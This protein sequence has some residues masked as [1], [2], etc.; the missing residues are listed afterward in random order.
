MNKILAIIL[1]IGIAFAITTIGSISIL[2]HK[3]ELQIARAATNSSSSSNI[4][5]GN[6]TKIQ[7]GVGQ[8]NISESLFSP[9]K[10]QIKLG[11]SVTWYN[12][13]P[14]AEPHTVSFVLDNKTMTNIITPFAIRNITELVPLPP[15][16]NSQPTTVPGKNIVLLLN[17][18]V[19]NPTII[20][21]QGKVKTVP[22]NSNYTMTSSEK[23]VN[24][25]FIL[26]K[27]KE[28]AYPGSG[29]SFT[30]RF[31]KAGTYDYICV[32]HPWMKG[33]VTVK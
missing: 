5:I 8:G 24:S 15:G 25:G 6:V 23:F 10:V 27:G 13:T 31:E 32:I 14:V 29:N 17:S 18:R 4:A 9:Q 30:I 20:D 2:S 7:A 12:P 21:S 22:T 11:D 3:T 19:F 28:Q 1:L 16:S 26:P 33:T